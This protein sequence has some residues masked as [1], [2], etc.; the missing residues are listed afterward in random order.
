MNQGDQTA[1]DPSQPATAHPPPQGAD[2]PPAADSPPPPDFSEVP[3][4]AKK[5]HQV[6]SRISRVEMSGESQQGYA[7]ATDADI[8]DEVRSVMADVGVGFA[9]TELKRSI[10]KQPVKKSKKN[11]RDWRPMFVGR[12]RF[13]FFDAESGQSHSFEM[14]GETWATDDKAPQKALTAAK[15]Y[16]LQTHLLISTGERLTDEAASSG[17]SGSGGGSGGSS[18]TSKKASQDQI[19]SIYGLASSLAERISEYDGPDPIV[20]NAIGNLGVD[21][22]KEIYR[23]QATQL[24]RELKK[25]IRSA[26]ERELKRVQAHLNDQ[27]LEKT[28]WFG[29]FENDTVQEALEDEKGGVQYFRWV[30]ENFVEEDAPEAVD[31]AERILKA[32]GG[33]APP[34][35]EE[36]PDPDEVLQDLE[37]PEVEETDDDIPL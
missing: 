2:A 7:Y 24:I 26:K 29:K 18:P 30:K 33:E 20:E 17:G 19:D 22:V 9:F 12:Y 6:I 13:T 8:V 28:M 27:T 23:D 35:E 11:E 15:K 16:A 14:S 25:K 3:E 10:R 34:G 1:G 32:A 37:V 31:L 5:L 36:L 4:L 21:S